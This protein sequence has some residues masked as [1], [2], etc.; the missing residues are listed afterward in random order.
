MGIL[1]GNP[2]RTAE[3]V[4]G[5][6]PE[7]VPAAAT[8]DQ[9]PPAFRAQGDE[10]RAEGEIMCAPDGADLARSGSPCGRG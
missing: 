4:T 7:K 5:A 2:N 1:G 6:R 9:P 3:L 8:H 10:R